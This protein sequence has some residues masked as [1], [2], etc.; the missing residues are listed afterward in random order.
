MDGKT[1]LSE[2]AGVESAEKKTRKKQ[3][4]TTK[5]ISCFYLSAS[6][7]ISSEVVDY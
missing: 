7:T 3:T 5:K 1:E 4:T 6:V 2:L